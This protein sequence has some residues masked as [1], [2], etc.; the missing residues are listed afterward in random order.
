MRCTEILLNA[1]ADP[2]IP[3]RDWFTES[4]LHD[5]LAEVVNFRD[6]SFGTTPAL[7][8]DYDCTFKRLLRASHVDLVSAKSVTAGPSIWLSAFVHN[9][10]S[11]GFVEYLLNAGCD[12]NEAT[13]SFPGQFDGRNCLYLLVGNVSQ[14]ETSCA[15]DT[16]RFLPRKGVDV[17]V[18]DASGMTISDYIDILGGTYACYRRDLWNCAL[19]R[20]GIKTDQATGMDR[21]KAG[22]TRNYT[23]EHYRA[24]CYLDTWTEEDLSCQVHEILETYPWTEE[25]ALELSHIRH[26]EEVR[27]ERREKA[28]KREVA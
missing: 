17:L 12:I 24:L 27:R 16:L 21:R 10:T 11:C 7:R 5:A 3:N 9:L 2:S 13:K 26:E 18:K 19:Q 20:E 28:E 15:F 25:E 1:G 6:L 22:Y 23:P 4:P 14:P 8:E